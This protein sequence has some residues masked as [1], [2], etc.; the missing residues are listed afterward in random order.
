MHN[1][2]KHVFSFEYEKIEVKTWGEVKLN[3]FVFRG[4]ANAEWSLESSLERTN[5]TPAKML[6]F[7]NRTLEKLDRNMNVYLKEHL[8]LQ[9]KVEKLTLLQHYGAATRLLD[10]TDSPYIACFFACNDLSHE[11]ACIW[12]VN[13]ANI[14]HHTNNYVFSKLSDFEK[15]VPI[16][17]TVPHKRTLHI[18][19]G[20]DNVFNYLAGK[21]VKEIWQWAPH[22]RNLR[23]D[24]QQG[25]FLAA[26]D[27]ESGFEQCLKYTL[28]KNDIKQIIIPASEKL[29]AMQ[30]LRYMNI[31]YATLF[32]GIDGFIKNISLD[33]LYDLNDE[34]VPIVE[35]KDD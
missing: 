13:E 19:A 17:Y 34:N 22:H 15:I 20:D 25:L 24:N 2:Q 11:D 7:E 18:H 4:H 12:A 35:G 31:N 5:L 1:I 27:L 32:P 8:Y 16:T 33:T 10:W 30:D 28:P 29:C 3:R 14:I 21:N 23:I 6:E 9:D 26:E